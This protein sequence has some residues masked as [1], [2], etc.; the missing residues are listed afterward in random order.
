MIQEDKSSS[1]ECFKQLYTGFLFLC[2]LLWL[3]PQQAAT[4][5]SELLTAAPSLNVPRYSQSHEVAFIAQATFLTCEQPHQ[6][7]E[8][9]SAAGSP[10]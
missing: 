9:I 10:G 1:E 8:G 4:L 3:G 2:S 7:S 5:T 6:P